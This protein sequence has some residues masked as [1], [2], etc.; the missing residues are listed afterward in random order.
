MMAVLKH[1]VSKTYR[2]KTANLLISP[3]ESLLMGERAHDLR[4]CSGVC[5]YVGGDEG[6]WPLKTCHRM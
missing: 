5:V 6:Q 1:A 3:K 2:S 4:E